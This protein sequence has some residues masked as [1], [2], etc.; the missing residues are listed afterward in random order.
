MDKES[1]E[2]CEIDLAGMLERLG[3]QRALVDQVIQIFQEDAPELISEI[4]QGFNDHD[5]EQIKKSAHALKGLLS[6]FGDV[7]CG[8]EI[9]QVELFAK[10]GDLA[11][12]AEHFE[13]FKLRQSD[14]LRAISEI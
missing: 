2:K 14:L 13:R 9:T 1:A 8:L 7:D 11:L 4:E 10:S 6:N 5:S 12:A 3:G